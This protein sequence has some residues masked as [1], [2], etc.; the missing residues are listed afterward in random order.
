[1]GLR[2]S[3]PR[4][5]SAPPSPGATACCQCEA[6]AVQL[7]WE[8]IRELCLQPDCC[9][10]RAGQRGDARRKWAATKGCNEARPRTV[11]GGCAAAHPKAWRLSQ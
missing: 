6:G 9:Q 1:M 11:A 7:P 10:Q 2:R 4:N 5:P 3:T 8:G